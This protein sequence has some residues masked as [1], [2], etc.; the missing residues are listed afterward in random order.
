MPYIR[1]QLDLRQGRDEARPGS[2]PSSQD[3]QDPASP[4]AGEGNKV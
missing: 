4:D 1:V 3:P 2:S